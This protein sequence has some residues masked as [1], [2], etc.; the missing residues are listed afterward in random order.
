VKAKKSTEPSADFRNRFSHVEHGEIYL[1]HAAISPL[2]KHTLSAIRNFL[3]EREYG[4]IENFET[5][6]KTVQDT[7]SR[8][9]ELIHAPDKDQISFM[10]NTSD[11]ISAV[12]GGYLWKPGDEVI[13]NSIEFPANIQPFRILEKK[14]VK[15]V[16]IKPDQNGYITAEVLEQAIT[17]RTRMLSISAVQYLTGFRADLD[18]IGQLCRNYN[19]FFIVDAIQGLGAV[20]IDVQKAQIDALATGAHKWLMSPMG[21]GFLYLSERL[22]ECMKPAKTGWLSVENPWELSNYNQPWKPLSG[23]LETGTYNII[24]IIGLNESL[25]MILDI[26]MDVIEK[27]IIALSGYVSD[28]IIDSDK[29]TLLSPLDDRFRAGIVTF[30]PYRSQNPEES[31]YQLKQCKITISAREGYYRISPHFYNTSDETDMVLEYLFN[32]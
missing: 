30:K 5:W 6:M 4:P 19:I 3:N 26:G 21:T 2:P 31:V 10:G 25:K 24:G 20:K 9:C 12:A 15:P 14:G 18:S 17:P 22:A 27:K 11:A 7:R 32:Q 16:Y 1:N 8:I 29:A 23:H 28:N 13:L